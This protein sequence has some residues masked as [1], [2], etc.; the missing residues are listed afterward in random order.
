MEDEEGGKPKLTMVTN[1]RLEMTIPHARNEKEGEST[2][3]LTAIPPI[4]F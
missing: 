4:D 1:S 2:G 3:L